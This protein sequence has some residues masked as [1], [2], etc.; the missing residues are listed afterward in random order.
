M[1]YNLNYKGKNVLIFGLGIL[2]R[3]LLDTI[4]FA[5]KGANVLVTDLKTKEQ[6]KPAL[7][8]L[9]KYENIKYVLGKH[10][11]EDFDWAD[12]II[13][14]AD[15][16]QTSEFL[17][18]AISKNKI[19]EMDESLF[20]KH[21]PCAIIGIT[22][23]RG[24]TTTSTLISMLLAKTG[25]KVY[26]AGN[27]LNKATLPLL[28]KVKQDDLVVLELSSW[29]LQGFGWNK[30]S[31]HI[32]IVTNIY[33]DHL[34]RY[35]NMAEYINDKKYI[36]KFQT[37]NDFLILNKENPETIKMAKEAKSKVIWFEKA[38]VPKKWKLKI[39]GEHN[40]ENIAAAISVA[41]IFK[42]KNSDIKK[43]VES[44]KGVEHRLELLKNYNGVDYIND[45]T[46]TTP[47]AGQKALASIE[48]PIV[49]ICGGATKK[50]DLVDFAKDISKKTKAVILL[51]G[52]AT[53]DL[54]KLIISFGGE[55]L[56][57]GRF[58]DFEKAV[59]IAK[60]L[61]SAGDCVL[62]SPGCASFGLFLNE[63]DRGEK[64]KKIVEK[65]TKD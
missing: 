20:A 47:I 64:F 51:E 39:F 53:A 17:K 54:E 4:Y 46:S 12:L 32:S 7:D 23:T 22:G 41:K 42:I 19:V 10:Q 8:K 25:R 29:Q 3:G 65:I 57:K 45:S 13:R 30:I 56:I 27:I 16:P 52:T 14:N 31:P 50:I 61:A 63:Y 6:L 48:K 1:S 9:K 33:P 38:Q 35:S 5:K 37:K 44:F 18:Y 40:L 2:G 62:L 49:L 36:Y 24:K 59:N 34:N 11:K 26:L 58:N 55:K 28:D 43:I 60:S 15:V 21:C